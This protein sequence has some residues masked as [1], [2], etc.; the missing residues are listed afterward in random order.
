MHFCGTLFI[1]FALACTPMVQAQST[2]LSTVLSQMD[3]ASA[4]FKNAQADVK[5][6]NFTKLVN[7]HDISTGTIY[8][9]RDGKTLSM[10]AVYY[11]VGPDGKA[12]KAPVKVINYDGT[13]FHIFTPGNNQDDVFKAGANQAK[14]ESYLTLGFGGSGSDLARSWDITDGGPEKIDGVTTEKLD[15]VS[16]D[17]SVRDTFP[18]VTIWIDPARGISLKQQFFAQHGDYRIATY[19]NIRP[20]GK[21]SK[22]PYAIPSKANKVPH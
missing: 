17:P 8:V 18:K 1:A 21:I 3:K 11:S 19:S 6:D 20:N 4:Q 16:K 10:G 7:D 14:Y 22:G 15:L 13:T 12:S 5:Y 9:E 2:Q